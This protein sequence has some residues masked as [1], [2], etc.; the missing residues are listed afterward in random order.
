MPHL[1]Q[2]ARAAQHRAARA[3]ACSLLPP[4]RQPQRGPRDTA[5]PTSTAASGVDAASPDH[6]LTR[7]DVGMDNECILCGAPGG[8]PYCNE[9]CREADNPGPDDTSDD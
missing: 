6:R 9:D 2:A 8:Y 5:S 4:A 7:K 1:I 3:A